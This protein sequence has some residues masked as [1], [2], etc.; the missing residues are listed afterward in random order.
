MTTL[1]DI[2]KAGCR[3]TAEYD[4]NGITL[5][6]R[7][8][9]VMEQENWNKFRKE[10]GESIGE[11][12]FELIRIC[13]K[14]MKEATNEDLETLSAEIVMDLGNKIVELSS[15]GDDVKK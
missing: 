8:M 7:E 6:I 12:Y 4:M 9:S 2:L 11:L 13:C 10:N 15:K 14:E 5:H 3:K 1:D